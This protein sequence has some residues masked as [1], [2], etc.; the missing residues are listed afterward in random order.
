MQ[1]M[2]VFSHFNGVWLSVCLQNSKLFKMQYDFSRPKTISSI[3]TNKEM[4]FL[5]STVKDRLYAVIWLYQSQWFFVH[6]WT[7]FQKCET[8]WYLIFPCDFSHHSFWHSLHSG[9]DTLCHHANESA[10]VFWAKKMNE[11][12]RKYEDEMKM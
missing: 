8:R 3:R 11:M 9:Q 5:Q 4:L 12:I 2:V 7:K 10:T 6:T 1:S